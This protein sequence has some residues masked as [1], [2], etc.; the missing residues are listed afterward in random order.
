MS[1]VA[2]EGSVYQAGTLSGNPVAVAAG[3]ATLR[4]LEEDEDLYP[5]LE[6]L[7]GVL[8]ERMSELVERYPDRLSWQRAGAMGSIA[9]V[10]APARS[11]ADMDRSDREGFKT[12]FWEMVGRGFMIPPSCFEAMFWSAA[13][14]EDQIHAFA[15]AAA[16]ALSVSFDS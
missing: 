4:I 14:E 12:F 15:D 5:K 16:E 9:F 3:L 13:H 1:A 7:G 10:P 11:W 2:P 8:D 6:A